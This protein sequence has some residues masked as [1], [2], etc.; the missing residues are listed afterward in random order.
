MNL[1]K[2]SRHSG[3][4]IFN[5][6]LIHENGE[7]IDVTTFMPFSQTKCDDMTPRVINRFVND[8]FEKN[9]KETVFPDKFKNLFQCP[10][11][12]ATYEE[13]LSVIRTKNAHANFTLSG[14]DI[15]LVEQISKTL[16]ISNDL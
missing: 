15:E 2:F 11:K 7:S 3:R 8:S 12:I 5:V 9:I 10:I 14:F 1:K 16:N 4:N 6:D 13:S